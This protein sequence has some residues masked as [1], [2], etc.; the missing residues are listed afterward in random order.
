MKATKKPNIWSVYIVVFAVILGTVLITQTQDNERNTVRITILH[1]NDTHSQIK[2][3][4]RNDMGGFA[5][6]LGVIE[7]I[8]TE[9][10]N[11]LLFDAGDFWQGTPYFN[12][13]D[14]L[15]EIEAFN[16]MEYTAITL[17]NHEFDN[18]VEHLATML[19]KAKI[20]V[21][22]S[23][24]VFENEFL[25]KKVKPYIIVEIDGIRIGVIGLGINLDG[26]VPQSHHE[27]VT[28]LCPIEAANEL[29]TKLKTQ[30]NCDLVIVLSHLGLTSNRGTATDIDVAR[31]TRHV[32][33]IIGGH[34]HV[35][36]ENTTE[37][38]LDGNNVIIA[39][40]GRSG[41]YL[42]RIDLELRRK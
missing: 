2:P 38:N 4:E 42:G 10:Q 16:R 15:L 39:Q 22:N 28:Y 34:S 27:G 13:F 6:R 11:V 5:R 36:L 17:G 30:K 33:I 24:Y 14:G 31:N 12:F 9:E 26:F 19:R 40:I 21:V 32:D 29:S 37:Q 7:R 23:N 18:G 20:P 3:S 1:T 8:R 41:F 35:I 25:A